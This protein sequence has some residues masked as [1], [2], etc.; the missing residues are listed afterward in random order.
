MCY[1]IRKV[2]ALLISVAKSY[3]V[4]G[5]TYFNYPNKYYYTDIGLCNARM[6]YW[7]YNTSHI[8]E[9]LICS[10]TGIFHCYLI[11]LLFGRV[12]LF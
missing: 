3:N 4:K 12:E 2:A 6:S 5:K 8:T 11:D 10:K 7:Q 1:L 9:N